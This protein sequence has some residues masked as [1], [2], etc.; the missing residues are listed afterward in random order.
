MFLGLFNLIKT[1]L[2]ALHVSVTHPWN[3]LSHSLSCSN[4][5]QIQSILYQQ[6]FLRT[7]FSLRTLIWFIPFPWITMTAMFTLYI[8]Q[9]H[10][11]TQPELAEPYHTTALLT[12][13]SFMLSHHHEKILGPH[14]SR[15]H[16]PHWLAA[17]FCSIF[18]TSTR[19]YLLLAYP[20]LI[21][22]T[23]A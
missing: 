21:T 1:A 7:F 5:L 20:F 6:C 10:L 19:K 13:L 12:G 17:S 22:L 3:L 16:F 14:L 23:F 8:L 2:L 4:V 18:L 15:R 11:L 9:Y